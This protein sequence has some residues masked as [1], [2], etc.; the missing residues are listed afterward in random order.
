VADVSP[1]RPLRVAASVGSFDARP[2]CVVVSLVVPL[3]DGV[4]KAAFLRFLQHTEICTIEMTP[5]FRKEG[6]VG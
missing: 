2:G 1:K 5:D 3:D 4:V 6:A